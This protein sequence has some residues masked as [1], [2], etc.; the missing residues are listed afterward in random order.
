MGSSQGLRIRLEGP[1]ANPDGIGAT[2]RLVSES[3]SG[4][5]RE[6]HAGSGYWSQ[7]SVTQI[8]FP[9]EAFHTARV[10]WPGGKLTTHPIPAG[11]RDVVF[12]ISQNA[13]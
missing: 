2:I 13:P 6:I 1:S 10:R 4:P 11:Q 5:V 8:M 3:D 12:S 9:G 7:D